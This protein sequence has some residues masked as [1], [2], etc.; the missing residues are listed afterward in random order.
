MLQLNVKEAPQC[1]QCS[2]LHLSAF[3]DLYIADLEKFS[4]SKACVFVKDGDYIFQEGKYPS[5]I[6]CI[7]KGK[8]KLSRDGQE[9]REHI[10]RFAKE[11]DILGYKA[12]ITGGTYSASA[13][14][15]DDCHICVI[16][17]ELFFE[18]IQHNPKLAMKMMEILTNELNN[19][20]ERVMELAQKTVRER[21]AET[22][23]ILLETFGTEEDGETI[24]VSLTREEIANIVGTATESVIRLLADFKKSELIELKGRKIA[25]K[26]P[27]A[28]IKEA[29]LTD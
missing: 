1:S 29:H 14:A 17:R 3:S 16:P 6:F 11:G 25:I 5:G 12:L 24:N 20:E 13:V 26:K 28:L 10:V 27:I 9:G 2:S 18:T 8:I 4:N 7:H 21:L 23:L 15:L 19:A 22:L